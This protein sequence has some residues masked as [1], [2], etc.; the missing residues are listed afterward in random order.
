[1]SL[2]VCLRLSLFF[3]F[4]QQEKKY[5]KNSLLDNSCFYKILY[6]CALSQYSLS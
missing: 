2:Y 4:G 5:H 3:K 6:M 1:M